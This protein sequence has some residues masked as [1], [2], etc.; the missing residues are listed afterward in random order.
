ME[1]KSLSWP[2]S[3]SLNSCKY[4]T[5]FTQSFGSFCFVVKIKIALDKA[6]KIFIFIN[7]SLTA[8][9]FFLGGGV[10]VGRFPLSIITNTSFAT[11]RTCRKQNV[12]FSIETCILTK[13]NDS[14][15]ITSIFFLFWTQI[16]IFLFRSDICLEKGSERFLTFFCYLQY[17]LVN[18][19]LPMWQ[20]NTSIEC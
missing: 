5:A 13:S 20:T 11:T 2:R 9:Y 10:D 3:C 1:T 15:Q 14:S 7:R 4:F 8:K 18:Y 16:H 19:T 12:T 6:F 17:E